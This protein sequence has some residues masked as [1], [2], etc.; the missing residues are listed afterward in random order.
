MA[1]SK[2]V[3]D[4]GKVIYAVFVKVRDNTGKQVGARHMGISSEREAKKIEFELKDELEGF[5]IKAPWFQVS[6]I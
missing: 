3:S 1:I 5:K 6:G 4:T 2:K